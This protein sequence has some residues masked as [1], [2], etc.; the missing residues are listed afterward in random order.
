MAY[1][2]KPAL[3][4]TLLILVACNKVD[5]GKK[6]KDN[7]LSD[8]IIKTDVGE[9]QVFH[10]GHVGYSIQIPKGWNYKNKKNTALVIQSPKENETDYIE[11]LDVVAVDGSFKQG[12]KGNAIKNKIDFDGFFKS[13][14][15]NLNTSEFKL[16]VAEEG[17]KLINNKMAKWVYLKPQNPEKDLIILKY[18]IEADNRVYIVSTNLREVTFPILGPVFNEITESFKILADNS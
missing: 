12:E 6:S 3:L 16:S 11:S 5:D 15:S 14:I 7:F 8:E 2:S 10:N 4:L 13:H 9:Y 17:E 18:F 1:F